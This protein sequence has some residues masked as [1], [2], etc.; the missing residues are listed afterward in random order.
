VPDHLSFWN[1]LA[2]PRSSVAFELARQLHISGVAQDPE[3]LSVR[4]DRLQRYDSKIKQLVVS[5]LEA[6]GDIVQ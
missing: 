2:S 3:A 6:Y 4:L 5:E 1:R